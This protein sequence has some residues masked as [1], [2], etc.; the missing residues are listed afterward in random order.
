MKSSTSMKLME[1]SLGPNLKA[2]TSLKYPN[3][4]CLLLERFIITPH[5]S[6]YCYIHTFVYFC[7]VH[8]SNYHVYKI[9]HVK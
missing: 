8:Q 4:M 9:M 1:N 3:N 5:S 6:Y 7:F 2:N